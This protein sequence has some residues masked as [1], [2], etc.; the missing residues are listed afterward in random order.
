MRF[1]ADCIALAFF[2]AVHHH[3]AVYAKAHRWPGRLTSHSNPR[4][5][6]YPCLM[7]INRHVF[8]VRSCWVRGYIS[9]IL[10]LPL[11]A[12]LPSCLVCV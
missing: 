1:S 5:N 9:S 8:G 11:P 6:T 3:A 10:S 4:R 2:S 7:T 12:A